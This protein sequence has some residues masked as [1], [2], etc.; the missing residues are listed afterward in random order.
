M[1]MI[2]MLGSCEEV[3]KSSL[4]L[5]RKFY[6]DFNLYKI[7]NKLKRITSRKRNELDRSIDDVVPA[8]KNE[9][10][11]ETFTVVLAVLIR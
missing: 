8:S 2:R 9:L 11:N 6:L 3:Q 4:L 1:R 7:N 5:L 10:V